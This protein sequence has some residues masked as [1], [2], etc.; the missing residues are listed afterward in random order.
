MKSTGR[1]D[2][3]TSSEAILPQALQAE[4][5]ISL[6]DKMH[7]RYRGTYSSQNLVFHPPPPPVHIGSNSD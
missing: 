2:N 3:L 4:T 6:T 5:E 1:Y 7:W